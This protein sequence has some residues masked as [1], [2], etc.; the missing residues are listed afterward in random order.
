[1]LCNQIGYLAEIVDPSIASADGQRCQFFF[2]K[3]CKLHH[4]ALQ[5]NGK[6]LDLSK[7]VQGVSLTSETDTV[8]ADEPQRQAGEQILL[9][10]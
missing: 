5:A 3:Q 8:N 4:S 10:L 2:P 1:M 7:L 6:S 9:N